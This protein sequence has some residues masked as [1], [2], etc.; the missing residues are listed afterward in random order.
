VYTLQGAWIS[1]SKDQYEY[2]GIEMASR[3]ITTVILD[4]RLTV[5]GSTEIHH[6]LHCQDVA[7]S[8]DFITTHITDYIDFKPTNGIL[9]GHS[10]GVHLNGM[11][12]QNKMVSDDTLQF[13]RKVI[14]LEGI[15]AI[16]KLAT[17][18]PLYIDW[19]LIHA[20]P[21]KSKWSE[22]SLF[23]PFPVDITLIIAHSQEDE[24]IMESHALEY[25]EYA[26][27]YGNAEYYNLPGTHD[28]CLKTIEMFNFL[29]NCIRLNK[30]Y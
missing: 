26:N 4:Y 22:Y 19:F 1:N 5:K 24:L 20:F 15:Y 3:G 25:F 6:P 17:L 9:C 27:Q 29:E 12:L 13:I 2:L 11:V 16:D 10:C 28:E 21:D 7:A 30:K 18:Y 14:N 23:R 8:L